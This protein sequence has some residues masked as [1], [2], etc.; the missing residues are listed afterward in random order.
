MNNKNKLILIISIILAVSLAA[1][2]GSQTPNA[3]EDQAAATTAAAAAATEAANTAEQAGATEATA[4]AAANA[5]ATT[6]AVTTAAAAAA[7]TAAAETAASDVEATEQAQPASNEPDP[8][9][10]YA[11]TLTVRIAKGVESTNTYPEGQSATDNNYTRY[12]KEKLNINI[13]YEWT[14]QAGDAFDQRIG[15]AIS[16][17]TLPD[18]VVVSKAPQFRAMV[19][20]ELLQDIGQVIADYASPALKSVLDS[21]NGAALG[22]V[23]FDGEVLALPNVA[24][25]DD[26]YHNMWIR[27]DWLDNV[28]LAPPK[29]I[30]ELEAVLT[31]FVNNDPNKSGANDTMGL[32]GPDKSGLLYATF[33][34]PASNHFGFDAVFQAYRAYPGFWLKGAAGRAVYGSLEPETKEALGKLREWYAKGLIDSEMGIREN[35]VETITSGQCGIFSGVWWAGYWP[36]PDAVANF[37]EST[38]IAYPGPFAA[39]GAWYPHVG[40]STRE[41]AV[42]N[43]DFANP[44]A[45]LKIN[46]LLLRDESTFDTSAVQI[47]DYPLR[48]VY[49]P[50]DESTYS[51]QAIMDYLTGAKQLN[52]IDT[53][54]Y[55]LLDNDLQTAGDVKLAPYDDFSRQ[56][57]NTG[58][59]NFNRMYS[60]LVGCAPQMTTP[61]T[62]VS[63]ITY[64]LTDSMER[65]WPNLYAK[66]TE[67]FL[68]IITGSRS[69]EEFDLFIIE[70]LTQGGDTLIKE[71]NDMLG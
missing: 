22:N 61:F 47:G 28:G 13:E 10:P 17:G 54:G 24:P 25:G 35:K 65:Y 63:S 36:L 18:M 60:L 5:D 16:S 15:L 9:E 52:Q 43:R 27:K 38:W 58:H 44:E 31:A 46:N 8:F 42:V 37:P 57:W 71:V 34:E 69:L 29:T 12:I 62:P 50:E 1:C 23:T 39:D 19:K 67:M 32:G 6:A 40:T 70:W 49:A 2:S 59:E 64:A 56:Y 7:T 21:T 66:E 53:L 3:T 48:M 20:N 4:A 41:Y 30:D 11:E 14:A 33:L 45:L 26:D 68:G 55:K 51:A